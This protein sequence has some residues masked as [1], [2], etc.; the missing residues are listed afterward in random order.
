M[1]SIHLN[2]VAWLAL[3]WASP[4]PCSG[5]GAGRSHQCNWELARLPTGR[6]TEHRHQKK[7]TERFSAFCLSVYQHWSWRNT[8][9]L[10]QRFLFPLLVLLFGCV[11]K[12]KTYSIFALTLILSFSFSVWQRQWPGREG[13]T[14]PPL[15]A[16]YIRHCGHRGSPT[17]SCR[18]CVPASWCQHLSLL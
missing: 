11:S 1:I 15:W 12:A 10:R 3:Q 16:Q 6:A 17:R 9:Q 2:P 4:Q 5:V 14:L 18:W 8:F 7:S 13:K